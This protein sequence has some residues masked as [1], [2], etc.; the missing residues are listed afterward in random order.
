MVVGISTIELEI[1]D[2]NSLKDRRQVL[3]SLVTRLG[4]QF[5]ISVAQLD[6]H[7]LWNRATL[8]IA[9]VSNDARHTD[10][11]LNRVLELI[12]R[13]PRVVVLACEREMV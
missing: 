3:Q 9:C 12:D 4:N 6:T 5:N 1:C 11:I 10:R 7:D 2:S 13:D 8:G